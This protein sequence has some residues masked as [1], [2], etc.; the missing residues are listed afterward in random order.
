[1]AGTTSNITLSAPPSIWAQQEKGQLTGPLIDLI[2]EIFSEIGISV[3]STPLPWARAIAQMESGK[4]D[5]IPVIFYTKKRAEFMDFSVPFAEVPASVFV[6]AGNT[7]SYNSVSDL[8]GKKGLVMR[9]DSISPEFEAA[10]DSLDVSEIAGYGQMIRMLADH[11]ADYA[12]AAQYGFMIQARKMK[13]DSK[14]EIIEKPVA[15]RD[16]HFAFSKKSAYVQYLPVIN[17]KLEKMKADGRLKKL[18]NDMI[19][20][21]AEK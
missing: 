16:L 21:A 17:E 13:N 15:S 1:M 20:N 8:I 2:T 4:L 14:I 5:M 10:R 19:V 6:S 12:V 18:V 9:G 7:F 11:R 3:T